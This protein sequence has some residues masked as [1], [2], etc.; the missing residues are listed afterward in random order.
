MPMPLITA[1]GVLTADP[2]AVLTDN[3]FEFAS[4]LLACTHGSTTFTLRITAHA[5]DLVEN[6]TARKAGDRLTV[7]GHMSGLAV[8]NQWARVTVTVDTIAAAAEG[9][10]G[11]R[12]AAS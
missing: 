11:K 5:P 10:A 12:G 7:T 2:G 8:Q 6:L 1:E 9:P 4:A 3:G